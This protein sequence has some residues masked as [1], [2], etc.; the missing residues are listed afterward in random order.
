MESSFYWVHIVAYMHWCT[1]ADQ[2][3]TTH[4]VMQ[5]KTD[6]AIDFHVNKFSTLLTNIYT[7]ESDKL[8]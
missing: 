4:G 2:L 5:R 8:A 1:N 3:N 6:F 7:A